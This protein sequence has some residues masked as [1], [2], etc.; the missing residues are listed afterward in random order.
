VHNQRS[1][2]LFERAR[3][4]LPG[5]VNSPVRAFLR[6]GGEPFFVARGSG[7]RLTDV[8][9]REYLDFVMSWGALMVGHAHPEIT[10]ALQEAAERGTSYGAPCEAEV[11]IAELVQRIM[12]AVEMMR[13]VNSGTEATLSA[14]RLAR[15]ATRRDFVLKFSG[16]YHGH[17]DSF[18][19]QAG[20]GVATLGLPDS[21]G[22]PAELA[23]LTLT[24]PYNDIDGV[25]D[26][27]KERGEQIACVI[28]E[29]VLGNSGFI[30]P[31]EGFL[32]ELRTQTSQH[33]ALLI[34]DEVMTGFRV[35]LG[36]AQQHFGIKP[37]LT[38]LGKVIGGGLPVGAYGG[39]RA[40][41]E[42]I[43]PAGPIYQAG[44]LSGNPLAMTAG[45]TQLRL[46]CEAQPYAELGK[47]ARRLLGDFL[48]CAGELGI[49]AWGDA[50]GAL[51]GFHFTEGP[52]TTFEQAKQADAAL[53]ARFYRG[54][55]RRGVFLPA[56]PFEASFL[57]TAHSDNDIDFALEQMKAALREAVTGGRR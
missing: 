3:Q 55:L 19:V 43:A 36:G 29:P 22:V 39:S 25:R 13:F 2:T 30:P 23:Q 45:H 46:L 8:D 48:A 7:A 31:V 38:T 57:S 33:G 14:I 26:L 1:A 4:L 47:R 6:V 40:L 53:F 20:S 50:V 11:A 10:R 54:C 34:F 28:V 17:G 51:M 5:G 37:D 49:P 24:L 52:V 12:P 35:A 42:Q 56:S 18:L 41:M 16:C 32:A 27:F 44:T 9:G 15:G 21:P